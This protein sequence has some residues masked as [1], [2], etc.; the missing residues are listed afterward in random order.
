MASAATVQADTTDPLAA[1]WA[2]EAA[3]WLHGR[4]ADCLLAR[5][6]GSLALPAGDLSEQMRETAALRRTPLRR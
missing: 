3:A 5:A 1:R 6:P 2:T 4:A